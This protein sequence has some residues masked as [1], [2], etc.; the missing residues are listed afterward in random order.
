MRAGWNGAE[1][2]VLAPPRFAERARFWARAPLAFLW[3]FGCFAIFMAL[4]GLDRLAGWRGDRAMAPGMV[5]IWARGAMRLL[6]L[7][8][9]THGEPMRAP[10]AMVANHSSWIDI[11]ALQSVARVAFVSKAEV[12][13]WPVIGAIGRAIGTEFIERRATE[14]RR[15]ADALAER[16]ARGDRLCLFPEGTSSDGLRVLPFKSALFG[17]F[18]DPPPGPETRIQPVSLRYH[19]RGDLPAT[20]YGWWGEMDFGTHLATLLA[21]SAGGRVTITFHAP[22]DPRD[23]AERKALAAVAEKAVRSG[24]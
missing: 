7:H 13:G 15:Q 8:V 10:G 16:L 21:R 19:P 5:R 20:L 17:M 9:E 18:L 14:A 11:V 22:I 2:P 1:P 6:G 12:G 24:F 23:A 3:L 4:K